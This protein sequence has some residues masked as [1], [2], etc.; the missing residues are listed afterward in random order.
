[1]SACVADGT[2]MAD[3][4]ALHPRTF[5]E[6]GVSM[7]KAGQEGGFLEDVLKRI[8]DFTE[9]QEDLKSKVIGALA[10]PIFLA[11]T[12]TAILFAL[13]IFFVPQFRPIF[14]K[15][16]EK[17]ELPFVTTCLLNFSSFMI[18]YWWLVISIVVG[19]VF[20]YKAWAATTEGRKTMDRLRLKLPQAGTI[21]LNLAL[22]RL[23]AHPGHADAQRHSDLE[24]PAH[25]QGFRPAT[26]C[27]ARPSTRPPTT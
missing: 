1:M 19:S 22:S 11:C 13:V 2:S 20:S 3:A 24:R 26:R 27:S 18:A 17:G 9:Q 8:A 6:L 4:M 5:S 23:H 12:G 25:C 21:Y 16:E 15:L 7:I 14:A 10:Y